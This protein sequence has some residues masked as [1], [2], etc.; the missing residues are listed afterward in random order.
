MGGLVLIGRTAP[1]ATSVDHVL[2]QAR[3]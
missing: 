1:P 2:S 3:V